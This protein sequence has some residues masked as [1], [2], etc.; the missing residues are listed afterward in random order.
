M[1]R[2]STC[3]RRPRACRISPPHISL[4]LAH[5]SLTPR[6]Y[7]WQARV[8]KEAKD[9]GTMRAKEER[10]GLVGK[11]ML[12]AVVEGQKAKARCSADAAEIRGRYGG[13]VGE[14]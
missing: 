8:R 6:P 13:D 10:A 2:C 14:M 9:L 1:G 11:D 4:H 3:A 12:S 7:I 5:I